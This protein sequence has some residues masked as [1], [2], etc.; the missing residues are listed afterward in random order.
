MPCQ[1]RRDVIDDM[2]IMKTACQEFDTTNTVMSV[3]T[4]SD[5]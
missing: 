2:V 4:S 1:K 3:V 5:N